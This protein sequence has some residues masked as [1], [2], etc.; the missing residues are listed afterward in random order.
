L[1]EKTIGQTPVSPEQ[2]YR[3]MLRM[4]PASV[5]V[6]SLEDGTIYDVS[7]RF[8]QQSGFSREEIIGKTSLELGLWSDP[9]QDRQ[10]FR[11]ILFRDGLCRNMEV[12]HR[13]RSGAI[14]TCLDSGA[15]ITI[16]NERY[17]LALVLDITARK[18]AE[19]ALKE[20]EEKYRFITEKMTDIVWIM[21]LDLRTTYVTPSIKTVLGFTQEERLQQSVEEQLTPDSLSYGL[22]VMARELA[23][24][25]QGQVIPGRTVT[26]LLEYY[27]KDGRTRWLETIVSGIRDDQGVLTG[28][29]GVSRD[30]TNEKKAV[31]ELKL[32]AENLEEA[33]IAMR[34]LMN[35]KDEDRKDMEEKLQSNVNN[36]VVPYLKML[37]QASLD[38]RY[39]K[40][41]NILENNLREVLSPFIGNMLSSYK[42]LTPHEI[43]IADLIRRGKGTKEIA[44]M[45]NVSVNTVA[46]HRNNIRKKLKLKNIKINL[47]SYLQSLS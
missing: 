45:I 46:T 35:R 5:S 29:H 28:L 9:H 32:F 38:D 37:K 40:Y 8:C 36:L 30:V 47:R 43:Q 3:A 13:D 7:D 10:K 12:K 31:N 17:V 39:K 23:L 42:S 22:E 19:K 27:H 20:S 44:N 16:G 24:E 26:L 18:Q 34:V 25:K 33:N 41:L 11:E 15:L 4:S 2:I 14:R 1:N 6:A 21:D